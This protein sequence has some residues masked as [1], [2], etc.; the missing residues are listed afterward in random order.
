MNISTDI[1][2]EMKFYA[3]AHKKG[4]TANDMFNCMV[5]ITG[6]VMEALEEH[7]SVFPDAPLSEDISILTVELTVDEQLKLYRLAH[8][9]NMT[10]DEYFAYILKTI[11]ESLSKGKQVKNGM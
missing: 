1:K 2:H 9:N 4:I 7:K 5:D 11:F 10:V 3:M 6:K 8:K